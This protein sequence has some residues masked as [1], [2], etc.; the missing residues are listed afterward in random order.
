MPSTR[1]T[2]V[3]GSMFALSAC[4][5]A[6]AGADKKLSEAV[7]NLNDQARWGRI[8]DAV[9]FVDVPFRERFADQHRRWG[10]EIQLADSEVLNIRLSGDSANASAF[11]SYSWYEMNDMTLHETTLLQQWKARGRS[12]ALAGETVVRGDPAILSPPS[13]PQKQP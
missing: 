9:P 3:F 12:F 2:L 4:F 8:D 5:L 10:N 7:Y 11:V 13:K 6:G 1:I